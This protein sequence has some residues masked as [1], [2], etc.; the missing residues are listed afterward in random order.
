V[1]KAISNERLAK[2]GLVSMLDY[3]NKTLS[4][5]NR[6][7]RNRTYGGVRGRRLIAASYSIVCLRQT[8]ILRWQYV[9]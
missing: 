5:L 3:Y 4:W 2:F 9:Q 7:I 8:T 6:R 1:Q